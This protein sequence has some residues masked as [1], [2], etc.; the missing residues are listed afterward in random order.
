MKKSFTLIELL[1]VIAIIAIL[2]GMLLPALSKARE[3]ARAVTCL[4]NLKNMGVTFNIYMNDN[5]MWTPSVL[6]DGS[7]SWLRTL[8]WN[9]YLVMPIGKMGVAAC[10]SGDVKDTRALSPGIEEG[11]S[12]ENCLTSYGMWAFEQSYDCAWRFS[13]RPY[14]RFKHTDNNYHKA[15]PS[16]LVTVEFDVQNP[17]SMKDASECTLLADSQDENEGAQSYMIHRTRDNQG[18]ATEVLYRRHAGAANLVFADGHGAS[19]DGSTLRQYGWQG[20]AI[21]PAFGL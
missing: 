6:F 9:E 21:K 3:K 18:N 20:Y 8:V 17:K 14:A 7:R 5:D 15:Y 16:N 13:G 4:S 12:M 11:Q 1:V 10:P 2:A 19:A